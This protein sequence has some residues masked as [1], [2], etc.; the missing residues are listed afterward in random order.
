M[1]DEE[2]LTRRYSE[3][4]PLVTVSSPEATKLNPTRKVYWAKSWSEVQSEPKLEH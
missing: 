2:K 1:S 4:I 3:S